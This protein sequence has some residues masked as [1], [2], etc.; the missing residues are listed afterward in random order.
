[1]GGI[2]NTITDNSN[3]IEFN[4][5]LIN[6]INSIRVSKYE[7]T[8]TGSEITFTIP[9]LIG[10]TILSFLRTQ[11]YKVITSGSPIGAEV[12][13]NNTSGAFTFASTNPLNTSEYITILAKANNVI[14]PYTPVDTIYTTVN[15]Y[16]DMVA[17]L[18]SDNPTITVKY[19]VLND[20]VY[21][22]GKRREYTHYN[23]ELTY[24]VMVSEL[25]T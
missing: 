9:E 7:Y 16:N 8:A 14:I 25:N 23:N 5:L 24:T 6:D 4:L 2:S 20:T 19:V 12:L 13:F 18:P 22:D 17:L 11:N 10:Q 15:T 1:M 3:W 21:G